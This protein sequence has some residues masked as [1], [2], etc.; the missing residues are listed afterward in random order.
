MRTEEEIRLK[1]KEIAEHQSILYEKFCTAFDEKDK[2]GVIDTISN[3]VRSCGD[4]LNILSWVLGYLE[5]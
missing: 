2:L 4:K 5:Q 3:E 1:A